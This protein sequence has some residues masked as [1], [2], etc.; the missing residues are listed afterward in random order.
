MPLVIDPDIDQIAANDCMLLLARKLAIK[1]IGYRR[2]I[3]LSLQ[4][5]EFAFSIRRFQTLFLH[6]AA[7]STPGNHHP[8]F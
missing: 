7:D 4:V 6:D 5:P 8:L 1:F 2:I 3:G